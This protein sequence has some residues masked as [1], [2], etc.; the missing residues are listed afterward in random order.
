M[1]VRLNTVG[2]KTQRRFLASTSGEN[3]E[4]TGVE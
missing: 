2:L 3:K 1:P 4:N